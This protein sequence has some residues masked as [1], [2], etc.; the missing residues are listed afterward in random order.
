MD[1]HPDRRLGRAVDV[2]EA[3]NRLDGVKMFL[4]A[5]MP[6]IAFVLGAR[7]QVV[8]PLWLAWVAAALAIAIAASGV[9]YLFLLNGPALAAWV[10]LP[11]LLVFVTGTG[12]VR[13]DV[14]TVGW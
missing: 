1:A 5:E 2:F 13:G 14:R 6:V 12:V 4:L 8:L 7:V 11:L 9:G 3:I 10:S